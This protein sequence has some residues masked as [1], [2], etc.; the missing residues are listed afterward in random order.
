MQKNRPSSTLFW[1]KGG[2][3]LCLGSSCFAQ[4]R[5]LHLNHPH[6]IVNAEL[7]LD[8]G[9]RSFSA[10]TDRILQEVLSNLLAEMSFSIILQMIGFSKSKEA[11]E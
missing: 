10:V 3:F 5:L 9:L 1:R 4:I 7:A 6:P 2:L 11:C 8:E